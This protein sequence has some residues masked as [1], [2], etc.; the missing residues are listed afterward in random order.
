[1]RVIVVGRLTQRSYET[2]QGERRQIVQDGPWAP[3]PQQEPVWE[4]PF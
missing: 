3:Q 4:P 1:M 2:Q